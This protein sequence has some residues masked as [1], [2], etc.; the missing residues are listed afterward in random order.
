MKRLWIGAPLRR[1]RHPIGS[2]DQG[3]FGI[4]RKS[5]LNPEQISHTEVQPPRWQKFEGLWVIV[6]MQALLPRDI[7][8][9]RN[10]RFSPYHQR[11]NIGR[12]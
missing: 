8:Q 2:I 3:S 10:L 6:A 11:C 5:L 4:E 9:E 1:Y 12:R 7:S